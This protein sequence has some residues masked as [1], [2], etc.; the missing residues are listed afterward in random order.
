MPL[1]ELP[2]GAPPVHY[3]IGGDGPPLL[4]LNGLVASGFLWPKAWLAR[5]EARYTVIRVSNPGTGHTPLGGSLTMALMAQGALAV[6]DACGGRRAHVLGYSMGGMVAQT[7][8]LEAP[9]RV[10]SLVLCSTTTGGVNDTHPEFLAALTGSQGDAERAAGSFLHLLTN[11]TFWDES[12]EMV[13]ELAMA[14]QEAPTP[15]PTALAQIGA[16][17]MFNALDR[18]GGFPG[19]VLIL[20][21]TEDR[22]IVPDG[23]RRLASMLPQAQLEI[24]EG[25]GHLLP[26]EATERA[27]DLIDEF[28]AAI[29]LDAGTG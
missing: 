23:G 24:F 19:P 4:M 11:P 14:W 9:E 13:A 16:A 8:A 27:G 2:D 7:I 22:L 28:L 17:A 25:I 3:E 12:P 29:P 6:L 18:I 20:H 21:G 15:A 26:F 10:A 5:F 1:C